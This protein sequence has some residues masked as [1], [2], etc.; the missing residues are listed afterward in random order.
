MTA[1]RVTTAPPP[2]SADSLAAFRGAVRAT[3]GSA[4]PPA[5][6]GASPI[7]PFVLSSPAFDDTVRGLAVDPAAIPV[8]V[9]VSQRITVSRLLRPDEPVTVDLQVTGA[10]REARGVRLA[11]HGAVLD[12]DTEPIADLITSVLLN[13][14]V[15]VE[16]FG[17][18]PTPA[19]P[20]GSGVGTPANRT[21]SLTT[22]MIRRY[23]EAS[24]DHN[25]IHLD[26]AA[27]RAAGFDGV[28]AHGMSVLAA[29]T[30]IAVDEYGDGDPAM[31]RDVGC[32]FSSPVSPGEP[33]DVELRPDA[34][35]SVIRFACSAARGIAL[36]AGWIAIGAPR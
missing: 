3:L 34:G 33:V 28:I 25:P 10:R 9:H 2:A 11:L 20:A 4:A 24:G 17:E 18:M 26:D 31:I 29:V 19:A 16:P 23:A 30:E 12:A 1:P 6:P 13:A 21:W 35:G 32:R 15:T 36:K 8:V 22:E 14:A 7:H 5:R 27:A